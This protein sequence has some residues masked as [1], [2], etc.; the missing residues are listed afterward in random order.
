MSTLRI[1]LLLVICQ[2]GAQ[3]TA[4]KYMQDP[5]FFITYRVESVHFDLAPAAIQAKCPELRPY[6]KLWLFASWEDNDA[7]YYLVNGWLHDGHTDPENDGS[8]VRLRNGVCSVD[9]AGG[10]FNQNRNEHH[11]IEAPP[12]ALSGLAEDLFQ[13]YSRAFGGKA[14]FLQAVRANRHFSV[15]DLFDSIRVPFQQFASSP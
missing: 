6:A 10:L 1:L 5:I 11:K 9:S 4:Y 12:E 3:S 2:A 7:K 8:A 14:R 15:N 13:R